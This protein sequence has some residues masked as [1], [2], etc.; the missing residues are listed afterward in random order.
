MGVE[1][2]SWQCALVEEGPAR[3]RGR[4]VDFGSSNM[5]MALCILEF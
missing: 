2:H 5:R 4:G 3:A 1:A